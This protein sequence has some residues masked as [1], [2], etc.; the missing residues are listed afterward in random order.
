M[1][2]PI[3]KTINDFKLVAVI[4]VIGLLL[5]I[6]ILSSFKSA[7]SG[8]LFARLPVWQR[9]TENCEL[10]S[11]AELA[12]IVRKSTHFQ[13][14]LLPTC[15]CLF[16]LITQKPKDSFPNVVGMAKMV[17]RSHCNASGELLL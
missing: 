10:Q 16:Q 13:Q 7:G 1:F 2:I 3:T 11:Q 8:Y 4:T 14:F 15:R 6:Y 12:P 9:N 5:S 17:S